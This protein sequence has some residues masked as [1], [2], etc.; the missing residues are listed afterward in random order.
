MSEFTNVTVAKKANIYFG[1]NVTS[2][3]VM[4]ADGSKKTLGVML[5]GEYTF[6]TDSAE[7][8]EILAGEMDVLLP[9][10]QNWR[11]IQSGESFDI[12]ERSEFSLK[13]LSVVDY[14]CSYIE[15]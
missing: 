10:E 6:S 7:I 1:G 15:N 11:K 2:R 9:G 5:P 13:V 4:F 3:T 14:C 8:M 12:P